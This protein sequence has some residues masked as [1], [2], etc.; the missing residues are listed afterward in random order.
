MT[1]IGVDWGSTSFRAYCYAEDGNVFQTIEH[2]SGILNVENGAFEHTLFSHL[3]AHVQAGDRLL[4]SGM[5]TSRNGWI[6]T[7]YAEVPVGTENYL[8]LATRKEIRGVE[9]LFMPGISQKSPANVI[10]GE[11]LQIFGVCEPDE[12]ALVVLPGTHSKWVEVENGRITNF[13][14]VMTG[15]VFDLLMKQSLI[16][17]VADD[18][19]HQEDAFRQGLEIGS[20]QRP[21]A[22]STLAKIFSARSKVLLHQHEPKDVSSYLS[23]ILIGSEIGSGLACIADQMLPM[24]IIGN[25]TLC[26]RYS[27]G[28]QFMGHTAFEVV[29]NAA[30]QGF[31]RISRQ[32]RRQQ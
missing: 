23:G 9:L 5:I 32:L 30:E 28:F 11:E 25:K 15:E 10:R 31:A 22:G 12:H 17:M 14:T 29:D 13:Q 21:G 1:I 2:R 7:P 16:G 19:H 6:E 20:D 26:R 8:L 3:G 18:A 27:E 24:Y 4:F